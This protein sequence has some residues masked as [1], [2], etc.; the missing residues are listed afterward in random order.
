MGIYNCKETLAESIDSIINQTYENWELIMCDDASTDSTLEVAN[1]Y[2]RKD[3]R[4]IVLRNDVNKG[5][6]Y[7]L[8]KCI[9]KATGNYIARHDGDDI[10]K[11]FRLEKQLE[12]MK[13]NSSYDLVGT[14]VE[15]F[16][17][18]GIWGEHYLKENPDINDVFSQSMFSH[19]TILVRKEVI[20]AVKGYTVSNITQRTEDYDLY[21]KIYAKGFK[22][23]NLQSILLSVRRD[24]DAYRRRK[25]KYRIDES[26]CKLKAW[27]M[28]E[29]KG[30][31]LYIVILPVIKGIIPAYVAQ[32]YQTYRFSNKWERLK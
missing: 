21:A 28:L 8:N 24:K 13:N 7:S 15:Y 14:A 29:M 5:L 1:K 11:P 22:G 19:P 20:E 26:R 10:C 12:F 9:K 25:F 6:A 17:S 4:I 32:K 23:I 27:K 30:S 3:K 2:A 16:D 18:K 31:Q